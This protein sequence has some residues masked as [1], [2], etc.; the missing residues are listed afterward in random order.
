MFVFAS[1]DSRGN[2][3]EDVL[4]KISV[5]I[6]S[7]KKNFGIEEKIKLEFSLENRASV[8][9]QIVIDNDILQQVEI[10]IREISA[11]TT[12]YPAHFEY[13]SFKDLQDT[14]AYHYTIQ[15]DQSRI[16]LL[17]PFEIFTFT[18]LLDQIS[19]IVPKPFF[20]ERS[21]EKPLEE[22]YDFEIRCRFYVRGL[23]NLFYFLPCS[24]HLEVRIF[25]QKKM[26]V[27][28]NTKS[29]SN[30]T[31]VSK[32]ISATLSDK[33]NTES[34]AED[35]L[36]LALSKLQD[37]NWTAYLSY[38]NIEEFLS[39]S[40][41]YQ[42]LYKNTKS[43]QKRKEILDEFY[44]FF[45]KEMS[46]NFL[47]RSFKIIHQLET[48]EQNKREFLVELE[49]NIEGIIKKYRYIFYMKKEKN[50]QNYWHI[51]SLKLWAK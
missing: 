7:E 50:S 44:K 42:E 37:K 15:G 40:F 6:T 13:I 28:E 35:I 27:S 22:S 33:N 34:S 4:D 20:L 12:L 51:T 48:K 11:N 36:F 39:Y 16:I 38:V 24:N 2:Y 19:T 26:V 21:L 17:K 47:I 5:S 14:Y 9:Q 25:T 23:A 29:M 46:L 49:R 8:S 43:K 30:S 10:K 41:K 31:E 32:F 1:W 3:T 45:F 18:I